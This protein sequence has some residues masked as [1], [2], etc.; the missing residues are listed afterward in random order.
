MLTISYLKSVCV[1][2]EN[3]GFSAADAKKIISVF[4]AVGDA[5]G[6]D[7]LEKLD[8]NT[9]KAAAREKGVKLP[10]DLE[11]KI[12]EKSVNT[13]AADRAKDHTKKET[14]S[15]S[16][17]AQ[18]AA[19]NRK[20]NKQTINENKS[21]IGQD[22]KDNT[23][24]IKDNAQGG[25]DA[26][27]DMSGDASGVL[28]FD[29]LE[30]LENIIL[31]WCTD[32][33]IENMR[34]ASALQWGAVCMFIGQYIKNNNILLNKTRTA[35]QGSRVYD[36][37]KILNL[38]DLWIYLCQKYG[39]IPLVNDFI[40]FAGIS[41]KY[42]Y[43]D[44]GHSVLTSAGG[45]LVKKLNDIQQTALASALTDSKENPTGRIYLTKALHG[46]SDSGGGQIMQE[47]PTQNNNALP[48]FD[49]PGIENT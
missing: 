13:Y 3:I 9:I 48:L 5:S 12:K 29:F 24:N 42:F 6:I 2:L 32:N 11:K 7:R 25:G 44:N 23:D 22:I 31:Q 15:G 4:S 26:S 1:I 45:T 35:A 39:K 19:Q 21:D 38:S 43:G 41:K 30:T 36:I 33:E 20:D 14:A 49:T 46:W 16:H 27:G 10:A 8:I 34:K 28:P 47:K 18:K 40:Y 17:N 37:E